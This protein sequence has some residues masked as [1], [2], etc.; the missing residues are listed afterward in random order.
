M[1]FADDA[2]RRMK[3]SLDAILKQRADSAQ[4][5]LE[6]LRALVDQRISEVATTLG[7]TDDG[8][9]LE[10][11]VEALSRA[12]QEQSDAAAAEA[13]RESEEAARGQLAAAQAESQTRLDAERTVSGALRESLD[14]SLRQ[15]KSLQDEIASIQ[16]DHAA[17]T[18][19]LADEQMTHAA[20]AD[21][22]ADVR[23]EMAKMRDDLQAR[24][25]SLADVETQ[26]HRLSSDRLQLQQALEEANN[27][28][29]MET[30]ERMVLATTLENAQEAASRAKAESERLEAQ[31]QH[32]RR[33]GTPAL[34]ALDRVRTA[35]QAFAT[36]TS[37][38]EV[39][40]TLAA[41]LG[42]EF[43][44]AAIF[45][46]RPSCLEGLRGAG[47]DPAIAITNL[48]VP[49]TADNPL[50]RALR[51]K[52]SITV[53]AN[54]DG[55]PAGLFGS[56]AASVTAIPILVSGRVFVV[57]YG[58]QAEQP[59]RDDADSRGK[60]ADILGDHVSRRLTA[61]VTASAA[62]RTAAAS[63]PLKPEPTN[64]N[65]APPSYPGPVRQAPRIKLPE[66]TEVLVDGGVSVLVDLSSRGAQLL[67]SKAMRPNHNV[68]VMLPRKEGAL[69]CNGRIV[70]AVCERAQDSGT[71]LYRAGVH[72][73]D[74]DSPAVDAFLMSYRHDSSV[75][76]TS[77]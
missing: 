44:R 26:V 27:R 54:G 1:T 28:L 12:A 67:A 39:L 64:T 29:S 43:A 38:S 4:Q 56:S 20:L 55:N 51:E 62:P 33:R 53:T 7:D 32:E 2:R 75:F 34:E 76:Q 30:N 19:Q 48:K 42:R 22:L 8:G 37:A 36:T 77:H 47:L 5:T 74:V 72:F 63:A 3:T 71:M 35:L 58:E 46:V 65:D 25:V 15:I 60:I 66:G 70:W 17:V 16:Q 50:T 49:L 52:K 13:R 24:E 9:S 57:A 45:F 41:Q 14:D 10:P 61:I 11:V 23:S 21:T 68:R 6:A 18:A 40:E 59:D 69:P 31:I 73:T